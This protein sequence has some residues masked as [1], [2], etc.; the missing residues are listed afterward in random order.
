M[1]Q[2]SIPTPSQLILDVR[3]LLIG[4]LMLTFLFIIIIKMFLL[5]RLL[6][7]NKTL[8]NLW[9]CRELRARLSGIAEDLIGLLAGC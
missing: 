5:K 8:Y 4:I 7:Y 2:A 6:Q 9:N 3:V 1:I